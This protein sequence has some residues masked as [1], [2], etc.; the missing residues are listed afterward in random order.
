MLDVASNV[1]MIILLD[2][3]LSIGNYFDVV[4]HI[5][6]VE[7]EFVKMDSRFPEGSFSY[8]FIS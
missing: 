2:S 1:A 3:G 7:S 5:S 4:F 6:P 8:P